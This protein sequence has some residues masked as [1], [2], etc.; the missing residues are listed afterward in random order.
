MDLGKSCVQFFQLS[1]NL[2]R[3]YGSIEK[4]G[5][6]YGSYSKNTLATLSLHQNHYLI[7]KIE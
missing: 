3:K 7:L 4:Q 5:Q 1:Y 2:P 6:A